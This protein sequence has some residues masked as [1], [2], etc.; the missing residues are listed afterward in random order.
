MVSGK[1]KI[2]IEVPE[3]HRGKYFLLGQ[4]DIG[5]FINDTEIAV[6][7]ISIGLAADGFTKVTVGLLAGDLEIVYVDEDDK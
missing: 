1:T 6:T 2:R 5:V 4:R 7:D 3:K